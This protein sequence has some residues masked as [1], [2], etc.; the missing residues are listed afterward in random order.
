MCQRSNN[1]TW[2]FDSY[3]LTIRIASILQIKEC[4]WIY[5]FMEDGMELFVFK[6]AQY[7]HL[8]YTIGYSVQSIAINT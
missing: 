4:N 6:F 2:W 1:R 7:I 8:L 5:S 3:L